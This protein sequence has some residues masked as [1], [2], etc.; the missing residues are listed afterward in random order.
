MYQPRKKAKQYIERKSLQ[1]RFISG[2]LHYSYFHEFPK[3]KDLYI[4]GIP[5]E[6]PTLRDREVSA[7]A[8]CFIYDGTPKSL[9]AA[10]RLDKIFCGEPYRYIMEKR[11]VGFIMVENQDE[12]FYDYLTVKDV[13]KF[14]VDLHT[15]FSISPTVYLSYAMA[16]G[17]IPFQKM[18]KVLGK[19]RRFDWRYPHSY[20]RINLYL[21]MMAHCFSDYRL[22][23]SQ[24]LA[25]LFERQFSVCKVIGLITPRTKYNVN[26]TIELTDNLKWFSERHPMTYWIGVVAYIDAYRAKD[27][28]IN[29]FS[30]MRLKKHFFKKR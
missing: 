27:K 8:S 25:P 10:R 1:Y 9:E 28:L 26:S 2:I 12:P 29:K 20:A 14:F 13:Y 3:N 6:Y 11:F 4:W 17:D 22:D 24:L 23:E 19:I 18:K 15:L 16:E 7:L 21:F 30:K 5:S